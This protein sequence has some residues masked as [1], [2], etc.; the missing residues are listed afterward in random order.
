MRK[1]QAA[2]NLSGADGSAFFGKTGLWRMAMPD[3]KKTIRY[4]CF[5]DLFSDRAP[6]YHSRSVNIKLFG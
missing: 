1:D 2:Q 3:M 6:D 5:N 4:H